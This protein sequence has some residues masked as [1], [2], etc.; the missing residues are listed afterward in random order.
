MQQHR[1]VRPSDQLRVNCDDDSTLLSMVAQG[2][3]VT[4]MPQ[5]CLQHLPEQVR[6]LRLMPQ[7]KRVLDVPLPNSPSKE[8]SRFA[9]FLCRRFAYPEG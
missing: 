8:A 9:R 4:A 7:T 1:S 6:A 3:G 5:S 2:I